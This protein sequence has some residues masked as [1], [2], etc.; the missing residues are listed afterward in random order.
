MTSGPVLATLGSVRKPTA[1]PRRGVGS[2]SGLPDVAVIA[3]ARYILHQLLR[4]IT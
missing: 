2:R 1:R 4:G 3:V